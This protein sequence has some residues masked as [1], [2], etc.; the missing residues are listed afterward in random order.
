[1]SLHHVEQ[2]EMAPSASQTRIPQADED[3]RWA[4]GAE[5][6]TGAGEEETDGA[7]EAVICDQYIGISVHA[8][9]WQ[10][11]NCCL[12]RYTDTPIY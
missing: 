6:Q 8:E 11:F 4:Q 10:I 2:I 3:A 1:M 12:H 9:V 7:E 5:P